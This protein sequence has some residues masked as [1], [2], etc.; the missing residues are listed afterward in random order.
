[1]GNLAFSS[2]SSEKIATAIEEMIKR[3]LGSK[4]P[5]PYTIEDQTSAK[6]NLKTVLGDMGS[7]LFGGTSEFLFN[8]VFTLEQPRPVKMMINIARQGIGARGEAIVFTS[9]LNKQVKSE[10]YLEAPKRFGT[11]LFAGDG[12]AVLKLNKNGVLLKRANLF[13]RVQAEIG[14]FT[15]NIERY[16]KITPNEDD[17]SSD[18]VVV[19]LPKMVSMGFSALIDIKEFLDIA[20][21]IEASL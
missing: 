13:S 21:L 12:E 8:V 15:I 20:S 14:G 4:E 6:T 17:K 19:N 18:F 7:A 5:I 3:E 16:F 9:R 10:V 2:Q 1:M 11:P